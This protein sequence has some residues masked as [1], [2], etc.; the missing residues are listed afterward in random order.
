MSTL[1]LFLNRFLPVRLRDMIL[2]N[3]MDIK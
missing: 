1:F 2:L 3:H